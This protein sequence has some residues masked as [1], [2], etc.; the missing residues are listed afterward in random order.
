MPPCL[1]LQPFQRKLQQPGPRVDC[2]P[3][4]HLTSTLP[5]NI[6][7]GG[8]PSE[9]DPPV[10]DGGGARRVESALPMMLRRTPPIS[11]PA[12]RAMTLSVPLPSSLGSLVARTKKLL[13]R[14]RKARQADVLIV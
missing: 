9:G 1:R 2:P 13:K 4:S 8:D 11:H 10:G 3:K 6:T 14:R 7:A 5:D 12:S